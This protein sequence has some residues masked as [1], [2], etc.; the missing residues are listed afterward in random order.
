M[1]LT[2]QVVSQIQFIAPE[3]TEENTELVEIVA[4]AAVATL[5]A[6]L[7]DG[8][9]PEDCL[10]DFI[11]A[12]GMHALAALTIVDNWETVADFSAGDVSVRPKS[13]QQ[14]VEYLQTQADALIAPYL[15]IPFV[16]QG[17]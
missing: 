3:L 14:V 10:P 12:A 17:V 15:K 1:S 11:T 9:E 16:F 2:E 5:Q 13:R 8:V 4:Y 6:R 7:R